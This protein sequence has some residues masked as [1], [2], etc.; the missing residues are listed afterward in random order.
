MVRAAVDAREAAA[1]QRR[2][3]LV[4]AQGLAGRRVGHRL[5][6]LRCSVMGGSAPVSLTLSGP[7]AGEAA[8]RRSAVVQPLQDYVPSRPPW[9]SGPAGG[10]FA[11][12]SRLA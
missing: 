2:H 4:F 11:R 3:D 9:P 12:S 1:A 5:T 8:R 7:Q 10:S 6:M